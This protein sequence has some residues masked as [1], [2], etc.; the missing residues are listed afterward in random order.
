[1]A[2]RRA[3]ALVSLAVA[4][5]ACGDRRERAPAPTPTPAIAAEPPA[6]PD[7]GPTVDAAG[8][9]FAAAPI[10]PGTP[11]PPGARRGAHVVGG[12]SFTDGDGPAEVWLTEVA[13]RDRRAVVLAVRYLAGPDRRLVREVI[14]R[15]DCPT[16]NLT[17]F[18][19]PTVALS[20]HDG[21]G[22]AELGF[23]YFVGCGGGDATVKQLWLRGAD[24]FI[25]RGAGPGAGEP[26][27]PAARW[28]AAALAATMAAFDANAAALDVADVA[29]PVADDTVYDADSPLPQVERTEQQGGVEYRVSYP[30]LPML[31]RGDAAVVTAT[32]RQAVDATARHPRHLRGTHEG[33]CELGLINREIMSVHC[34]R[35]VSLWTQAELDQGVGGAPA[36]P[37]QVGFTWWR[38]PGRAEVTLAELGAPGPSGCPWVLTPDGLRW[39]LDPNLEVTCPT[40]PVAWDALRPTSPRARALIAAMTAA[41]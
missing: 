5:T 12:V 37:L 39:L 22:R 17:G 21:D 19:A 33:D 6:G 15:A 41:P 9:R 34:R 32:M 36:G 23:G 14:D 25:V 28:P 16:A 29:E 11:P 26:E 35:M 38:S 18:A 40:E 10:A 3:I 20:D 4:L 24:K 8:L 30:T 13:D 7:A 27:P 1:M 31:G 2:P